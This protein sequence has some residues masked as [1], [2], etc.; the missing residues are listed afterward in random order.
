MGKGWHA[1]GFFFFK[2]G[3]KFWTETKGQEERSL[4]GTNERRASHWKARTQKR[5]FKRDFS[6]SFCPAFTFLLQQ[7]SFSSTAWRDIQQLKLNRMLLSKS[8]GI[9]H[10]GLQ[11]AG[12]TTTKKK[13]GRICKSVLFD[14]EDVI[15]PPT[16]KSLSV[17]CGV[18]DESKKTYEIQHISLKE[19]FLKSPKCH[20][21]EVIY[22]KKIFFK[23]LDSFSTW[24]THTY[25]AVKLV[26]RHLLSDSH[27][28]ESGAKGAEL[29]NRGTV[30]LGGVM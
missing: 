10:S 22:K 12:L 7:V 25:I 27:L 18:S 1:Q 26:H 6:F 23:R 20:H 28:Q 16:V 24:Q 17:L 14:G 5:Q 21:W 30:G 13:K 11:D 19:E 2:V 29:A 4:R 9:F 8:T 3:V 15:Q